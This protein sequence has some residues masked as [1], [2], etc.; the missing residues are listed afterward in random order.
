MFHTSFSVW[1][2]ATPSSF[3]WYEAGTGRT[4][5]MCLY[6]TL[7]PPGA[8]PP[9]KRNKLW[10]WRQ[11][12]EYGKLDWAMAPTVPSSVTKSSPIGYGESD[13][14]DE[15]SFILVAGNA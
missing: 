2:G 3:S 8:L 6:F 11:W 15:S 12:L 13:K 4:C 14:L 1:F 10:K 9:N 5:A 7:R